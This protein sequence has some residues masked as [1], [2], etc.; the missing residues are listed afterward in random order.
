MSKAEKI[1]RAE[2]EMLEAQRKLERL[3]L[4]QDEEDR[5]RMGMDRQSAVFAKCKKARLDVG[6]MTLEQMVL[7]RKKANLP[8]I[9]E[10]MIKALLLRRTELLM[11][12]SAE[13][14]APHFITSDISGKWVKWLKRVYDIR[15]N[16]N[17][18][19]RM[20]QQ[21]SE[22]LKAGG[23]TQY[24]E[25]SLIEA[26]DVHL[27]SLAQLAMDLPQVDMC[28]EVAQIF[29]KRLTIAHYFLPNEA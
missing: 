8:P 13:R 22:K 26:M 28:H 12:D 23:L 24:D 2:A 7:S 1:R 25:T 6:A 21:I 4:N 27:Q 10:P 14:L 5:A 17:K 11:P 9:C 18:H 20:L 29:E 19:E 15:G 16:I 3:Q